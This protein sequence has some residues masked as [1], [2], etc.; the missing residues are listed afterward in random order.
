MVILDDDMYGHSTNSR[1]FKQLLE[2]IAK[3]R[4]LVPMKNLRTTTNATD[5]WR[6]AR[7]LLRRQREQL[8]LKYRFPNADRTASEQEQQTKLRNYGGEQQDGSA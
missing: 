4:G 1:A 6:R 8:R 5:D 3:I 2:T 7:W